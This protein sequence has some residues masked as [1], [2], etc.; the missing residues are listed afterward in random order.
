MD[1]E[2]PAIGLHVRALPQRTFEHRRASSSP[3]V[4]SGRACPGAAVGVSDAPSP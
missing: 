4:P 3:G 2:A 1:V